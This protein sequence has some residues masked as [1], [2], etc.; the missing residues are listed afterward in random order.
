MRWRLPIIALSLFYVIV[1][2]A[3]AQAKC[4]LSPAVAETLT[5][6][7]TQLSGSALHRKEGLLYLDV[8]CLADAR[9]AFEESK[10]RAVDE[11][12]FSRAAQQ[13]WADYLLKLADGYEAW[14]KGDLS[15]AKSVFVESSDESVPQDANSRAI[16]ALAEVLLQSPDA[17]LWLDLEKKLAIF[18]ER[19]FWQARRYRLV[20]GLTTASAPGKIEFLASRLKS[21]I[22]IQERL[23]DQILLVEV[24]T[25]SDHVSEAY[26]MTQNIE[27][28][29]GSKIVS[30]E[31]RV[32]Y[33][34][35]CITIAEKQVQ[36]GNVQ[37]T[38]RL[39]KY[40]AALGEMYAPQ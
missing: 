25:A 2:T 32:E 22:T 17:A 8:G 26:L 10:D 28:Y 11:P 27:R 18:D 5:S 39:T 16:F 24:L 13:A 36:S 9:N 21:D 1:P 38:E 40:R 37:A 20:H 31:L 4:Q 35:A 15:R 34:R 14:K 29:V 6:F 12:G 3:K 7:S 23:E 19:G 33:V 30:L